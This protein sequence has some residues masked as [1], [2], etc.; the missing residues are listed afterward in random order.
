[1]KI[2]EMDLIYNNSCSDFKDCRQCP[3]NENNLA[4]NLLL[5]SGE[6]RTVKTVVDIIT[7]SYN[8]IEKLIPR[9]ENKK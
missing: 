3:F 4:C 7:E 6:T 8:S 5:C 9:K 1:M 2:T